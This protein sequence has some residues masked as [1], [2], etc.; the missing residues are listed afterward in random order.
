[1]SYEIYKSIKQLPNGDFDCVCASSNVFPKDWS[2]YVMTYF[3]KEFPTANNDE[4]RAVFE[5]YSTGSGDRFY[6]ASW[7]NNISLA[8]K[9]MKERDYDWWMHSKD[10]DLWLQYAREFIEYKKTHTKI[11]KK[12][13]V[14]SMLFSGSRNYVQKKSSR[15]VWPTYH[16]A[17]AKRFTA[18]TK[19]EIEKLF[20]GYEQYKPQV[21]EA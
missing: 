16:K 14:V 2:H 19:E 1:M 3:S 12:V 7:K 9:F 4:L 11:T 18:E 5:L 17:D 6:S 13:F 15:H 21:E 8:S 10:K 20:A